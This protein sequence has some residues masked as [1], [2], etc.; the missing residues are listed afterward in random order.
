MVEKQDLKGLAG[1]EVVDREGKSIG[2]VDQVFNDNRSGEPEWIGVIMG[3][4][5]RRFHLVPVSGVE[6]DN[7]TLKVPWPKDRVKQAPEYGGADVGGLLGLGEYRPAISESK[8]K[9]AYAYY[10]I[11][12]NR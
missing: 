7:L 12:E 5:R 1:H 6:T 4:L 9:E 10:G 8:E 11:G 2:Y 3:G